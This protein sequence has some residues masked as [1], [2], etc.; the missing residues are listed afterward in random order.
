M[1][2]LITGTSRGLGKEFRDHLLSLGH[3]VV[4]ISRQ[5]IDFVHT[6]YTH[7]ALDLS[8]INQVE[9][10]CTEAKG[11][12]AIINSAVYVRA[13][14]FTLVTAQELIKTLNVNVLAPFIL[15]QHLSKNMIQQKF[16]RIINISSLV[17]S[18]D[19]KGEASYTISKAALE[20]MT[21]V[22]A[23]E[24]APF[25]ITVN[26]ITISLFKSDLIKNISNDQI[27]KLKSQLIVKEELRINDVLKALDYFLDKEN[28]QITR[29]N[30]KFGGV[31]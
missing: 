31:L 14:L 10:F 2:I 5:E 16:G 18:L 8:D 3:E 6:N 22:V 15:S 28:S 4:G 17:T 30:I 27:E 12:D 13:N 25:N 20:K 24:L 23:L 11:F 1:K 21:D 29:Q 19:F 26:T 9:K 7:K